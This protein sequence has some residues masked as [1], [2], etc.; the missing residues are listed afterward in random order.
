MQFKIQIIIDDNQ[1]QTKIQEI[2]NLEKYNEVNDVIGLSL[3]ESKDIL[4]QLQQTIVLEQATDYT[5]KH[6]N[7]PHC[8]Q[9]RTSKGYYTVEY[10]TLFGIISIPSLRVNQ[11]HCQE[12]NAVTVSLLK[13][14]L[15][16]HTSPELQYIETKWSSLMAY[17]QTVKLLHDVLPISVTENAT[18]IRRNLIKAAKR[19]ELELEDKPKYLAGC[20]RDWS[21]LPKPDKPF[22]VGLDGGY[23]RN[24]NEKK[25][26]FEVIAGKSFS[27][28]KPNKRF[29]FVQTMEKNPRCRLMYFL[30]KQGMQAN[31]QITFLSDGADNLRELQ[32]GMYPEAEHVLDW[33]HITMRIT[34]LTQFAKGMIHSDPDRGQDILKNLTSAKWPSV[35]VEAFL[36]KLVPFFKIKLSLC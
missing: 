11:C 12:S 2:I 6:K 23:V 16:E 35:T 14:W 18:T 3:S 9:L 27:K 1:G 26:N 22:T 29:G 5:K 30:S 10:R 21:N 34:V 13:D 36:W 20:F 17:G 28:S 4:T 19:C 33:F 25:T 32:Y 31:Q 7:C 8:H 24:W 15:P